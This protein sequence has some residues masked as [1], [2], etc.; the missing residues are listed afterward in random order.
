M[1]IADA[2]DLFHLTR[3]E[4]LR[5]VEAP[6]ALHQALPPQDL[7][8]AGDAAVKIV[9]DVEEGTVAIGN[10]GVQ[11]QQFGRHAV[12]AARGLA[13]FEL[14]DRSRGPHRPVA[15]QAAADVRARRN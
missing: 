14:P 8:T 10:T 7:V 13:G 9:G 11:R 5:R 12:L 3:T 6:D 1:L 4:P 2:V 15:E